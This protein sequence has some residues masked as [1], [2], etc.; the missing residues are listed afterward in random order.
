MA[1][2]VAWYVGSDSY[3]RGV[4]KAKRTD[5]EWFV[6]FYG[7]NGYGQGWSRWETCETPTHPT[8]VLNACEYAGAPEY[9]DIPAEDQLL[10]IDH[11]FTCLRLVNSQN[12]LRLPN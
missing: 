1:K 8:R 6:R 10:R 5:G 11:G 7:W 12:N 9:V 2:A 3:G 4:E